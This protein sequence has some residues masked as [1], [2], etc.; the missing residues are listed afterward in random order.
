MSGTPKSKTGAISR[1][2]AGSIGWY[3]DVKLE[4]LHQGY[5]H[6]IQWA[7]NL[8]PVTDALAFWR[9]YAWVVINSGMKNQVARRIW[10]DVQPVVEAGLDPRTV[11]NH[12][13]KC[14]GIEYVY[15]NREKLLKEYL[16][17]GDKL[18]WIHA[19]PWIGDI[20]KWHLAKNLG[21]DCAK[22]DRHLMRIAGAVDVHEFCARI[23]KEAG[24]RVATVDLVIW[25]AANLGLL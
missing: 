24:D 13:G 11:F 16:A 9:E 17:A 20:T 3:L 25:R 22:P 4:V 19:L 14:S 15:H 6:E 8:K 7:E 12:G 23:A 10:Q 18:A 21:H 5:G 1:Y 2:P